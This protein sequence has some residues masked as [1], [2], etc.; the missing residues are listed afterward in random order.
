MAFQEFEIDSQ[1]YLL[2]AV[3]V[4]L[5]VINEPPLENEEDAENVL[6]AQ[7]AFDVIKEVKEAILSDN[8]YFNRDAGYILSPDTDGFI[9]I[10]YNVLYLSSSDDDLIIRNWKLY[11]KSEQTFIFDEAQTVEII[12]NMPFNDL[13]HPLRHYITV[14]AARVFQSRQVGDTDGYTFTKEDE[15]KARMI[16]RR[17]ND[18]VKKNNLYDSGY[19][20]NYMQA[21]GL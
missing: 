9:T 3:N 13:T 11:S 1:K 15:M 7:I 14:S 19:G 20:Q 16:A 4:L 6:E 10:P 17:S 5:Q 8:W 21:G 18:R 12:W 2:H